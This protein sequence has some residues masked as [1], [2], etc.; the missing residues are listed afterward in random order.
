MLQL[1]QRDTYELRFKVRQ[2]RP[3][4]RLPAGRA[5][6]PLTAHAAFCNRW[7][8]ASS[9][10]AA[11]GLLAP[12]SS[13]STPSPPS[14]RTSALRTRSSWTM[15]ASYLRRLTRTASSARRRARRRRAPWRASRRLWRRRRSL[16]SPTRRSLQLPLS[17][18]SLALVSSP[19]P[20]RPSVP[21]ACRF[22]PPSTRLLFV[23]ART[24]ESGYQAL[25]A[26]LLRCS[27]VCV[28]Y[29]PPC[30][31]RLLRRQDDAGQLHPSRAARQ[32]DL[33]HRE[34]VW[35]RQHR[36][37]PRQGEYGGS[38]V[39]GWCLEMVSGGWD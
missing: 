18:A 2:R 9:A 27:H 20:R 35:R 24:A 17:L 12:C 25:L 23:A 30:P 21:T 6:S 29:P 15:A 13:S 14:R 36:H 4:P 39:Q 33:R 28:V 38:R 16:S 1:D 32:E 34:R 19:R 26:P 5:G 3:R 37:G 11:A 10:T 8:T 22:L 31:T 7:A